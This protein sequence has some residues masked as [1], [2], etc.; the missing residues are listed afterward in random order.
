MPV[1][2]LVEKMGSQ[3]WTNLSI[4]RRYK[5]PTEYDT[6]IARNT[7]LLY[8]PTTDGDFV[9]NDESLTAVQEADG[10]VLVEVEYFH[11]SLPEANIPLRTPDDPPELSFD[12]TGG[13]AHFTQ[14]AAL[15]DYVAKT[16]VYESVVKTAV[17]NGTL[18]PEYK[19]D[20]AI[21]VTP[22]LDVE[23][24]DLVVPKLALTYRKLWLRSAVTS[25][26]VKNLA[27]I[28][29]KTNDAP[30]WGYAAEELLF[31]GARGQTQ[32]NFYSIEY[33][34]D[35]SENIAAFDAGPEFDFPVIK[36]G[37]DYFWVWYKR[38]VKDDEKVVRPTAE[39]AY[40][41]KVYLTADFSLI[42][43]GT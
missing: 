31:M 25:A 35:A 3:A 37:H 17:G 21:G 5:F 6:T 32:G 13:T 27:R 26:F 22:D 1:P 33:I 41:D 23:G 19:H 24:V 15:R 16:A 8:S 4:R 38:T 30:F 39:I 9:R 10:T 2:S 34:F 18:K 14:K 20:G 42:G 43:I 29:G 7:V 36:K 28:T 40:V 11:E 12:T